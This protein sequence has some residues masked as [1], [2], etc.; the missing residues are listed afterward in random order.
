MDLAASKWSTDYLPTIEASQYRELL[1]TRGQGS[2][3][4][5][6]EEVVFKN[7]A[8]LKFMTAGG[9]DKKRSSYTAPVLV[10]TESDGMDEAGGASREADPITQMEQRVES[11]VSHGLARVFI[12]C[13]VSI[14][15]GR[16][17]QEYEA[18]TASYIVVPCPHCHQWVTPEREHFK[19]WEDAEDAVTAG[20]L[21]HLTCPECGEAW[22]KDQRIEANQACRMVHSG[23]EITPKGKIVGKPRRTNT[24]SFRWTRANSIIKNLRNVGSEEWQALRSVNASEKEKALKQ[25]RWVVPVEASELEVVSLSVQGITSRVSTTPMG[26]VPA[27]AD[28][29][30]LGVDA[31]QNL[32]HWTL[33]AGDK[34]R[35]R[36]IQIVDYGVEEVHSRQFPVAQALLMA[37]A[38]LA[39]RACNPD[40]GWPDDAGNVVHPDLVFYDAGWMP[41]PVYKHCRAM[42][43]QHW[44]AKGYGI[45]Q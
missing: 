14:D 4:G 23:Q 13:T 37:L 34:A 31:A 42:G 36:H 8:R 5:T 25:G 38:S 1:P 27:W 2:R 43:V 33:L 10:I 24:F 30:V 32:L 26:V 22:S 15:R 29:R 45:R 17:W 9:N 41:Q 19:G 18:G 6:V 39:D 3:G 12:E 35:Q 7:G 28:V 21:A 44:P 20:E 11:Y 40:Y 16:I